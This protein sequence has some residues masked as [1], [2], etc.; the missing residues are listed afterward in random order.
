MQGPDPR[1][2]RRIACGMMSSKAR[3]RSSSNDP[4]GRDPGAV[5]QFVADFEGGALFASRRGGETG[6]PAG[7]ADGDAGAAEAGAGGGDAGGAGVF[8]EGTGPIA[9]CADEVADDESGDG[10]GDGAGDAPG[11]DEAGVGPAG[12]AVTSLGRRKIWALT[13]ELTDDIALSALWRMA[14]TPSKGTAPRK[15]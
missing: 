3:E 9:G 2:L 5:P 4:Q 6:G 14:A 12:S 15:A 10:V 8:A 11:A 1:D 7:A 13:K